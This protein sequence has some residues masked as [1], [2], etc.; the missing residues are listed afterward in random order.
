MLFGIPFENAWKI[1]VMKALISLTAPAILFLLFSS[2]NK[3]T[4]YPTVSN[5]AFQVNE[6]LR[7]RVTYGLVDAG[8]ATMELKTST[9]K[10][11]NRETIQAV[12]I[13][14]TLGGFNS[15]FKVYDRYESYIDKKG[16]FPWY[17]VR[18]VNEGGY[19][20]NQDYTF[21]H[22]KLKVNNGKGKEFAIPMAIQDMVSS[23][24]YARTLTFKGIAKG[25]TFSF[26][27]FMD[28]E[29]YNLKIKYIGD[30]IIRIRKGKFSCH[31]FVPVVQT[32][33]YFKS[34]SDLVFYITKDENKIPVLVRAKI[35]VGV[36]KLQLVEW[37][38][39]KNELK[40]KLP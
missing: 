31:K 11:A 9:K 35:P 18:R 3:T 17:F 1:S 37:K 2:S 23:F 5:K 21:K 25:K 8:E 20:V 27:C 14:K 24:Y 30:E 29:I 40:S 39:L 32:G 6:K 10:G 19:T 26:K 38:G 13:G 34:E 36:V 22:D 7:Y 12:G 4:T 16:I 28:D 33:R 15:V